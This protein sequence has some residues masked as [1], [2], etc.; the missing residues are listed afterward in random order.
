MS[1]FGAYMAKYCEVWQH[2]LSRLSLMREGVH[3]MY[4]KVQAESRVPQLEKELEEA[5]LKLVELAKECH[6]LVAQAQKVP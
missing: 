5:R 3:D 6:V 2:Q 1:I 4:M